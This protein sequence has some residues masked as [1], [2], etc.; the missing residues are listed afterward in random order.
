LDALSFYYP[1]SFWHPPS[2]CQAPTFLYIFCGAFF[3]YFS[4]FLFSMRQYLIGADILEL[5]GK[6]CFAVK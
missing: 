3:E 5:L 4:T 1:P 2:F 6:V